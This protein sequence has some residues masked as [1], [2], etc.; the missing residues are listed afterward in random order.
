[1][2]LIIKYV[3]EQDHHGGTNQVLADLS[4]H[5]WIISAREA[6]KEWERDCMH[7]KRRNATPAKNI[8]APLPELQIRIL[9]QAFSHISAG[10]FI[11]KQGR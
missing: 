10:P 8:M 1:M 6:I 9:V 5:Y 11:T 2:R 7:C 4:A 3:H